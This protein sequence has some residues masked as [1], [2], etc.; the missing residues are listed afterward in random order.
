M[1]NSA[2]VEKL[3]QIGS[4]L[5]TKVTATI[6]TDDTVLAQS[7]GGPQGVDPILMMYH[8]STAGTDVCDINLDVDTANGEVDITA[9][10]ENSGTLGTPV[11]EIYFLWGASAD[12]EGGSI[13]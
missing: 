9:K 11:F 4:L 10:V 12:Q 6:D 7:H 2:T 1:A 13:P 3:G 8:M 5:I